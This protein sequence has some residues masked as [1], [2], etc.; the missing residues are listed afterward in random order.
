MKKCSL[1]LCLGILIG[2]LVH[3]LWLKDKINPW[4]P[5]LEKTSFE[6]LEYSV[7][8]I[9]KDI[10]KTEKNLYNNKEQSDKTLHHTMMLLSIL[11]N[12]YLPITQVRQQIYDADRLLAL[13]EV[14][15]AKNSLIK[16]E[17][18]LS[19]IETARG[20]M[21]IKK[22]VATLDKMIKEAILIIDGPYDQAAEKL[23]TAGAEANLMLLK[24]DLIL[25][26][27]NAGGAPLE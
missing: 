14:Q 22:A 2:A 10:Q 11:E 1:C 12:Y 7:E 27:V 15:K 16:A 24:G 25:S 8:N 9:M 13:K 3:S 20:S 23:K 26:G 18:R 21:V 19:R 17:N 4:K 6:Y 5:V